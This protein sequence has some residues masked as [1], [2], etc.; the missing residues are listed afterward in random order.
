[1]RGVHN[2]TP[3][4]SP[5][6]GH[7]I[8]SP[9]SD[10][11]RRLMREA[12]PDK[13][14]SIKATPSNCQIVG[15]RRNSELGNGALSVI[16]IRKRATSRAKRLQPYPADLNSNSSEQTARFAVIDYNLYFLL[17]QHNAY[18]AFSESKRQPQ[19]CEQ[20]WSSNWM[21]LANRPGRAMSWHGRNTFPGRYL[22]S[23]T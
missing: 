16:L 22:F 12:A 23:F 13:Q 14:T 21:P 19:E 7:K 1:L 5:F 11:L 17:K 8:V 20:S 3:S 6:E 10:Q 9:P 4:R 15:R 18:R 2:N